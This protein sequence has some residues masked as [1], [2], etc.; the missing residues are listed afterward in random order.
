MRLRVFKADKGDALLLTSKNGKSNMMIDGG[1]GGAYREHCAKTISKL[2]KLDVVY[3]SHIDRD[4]VEGVYQMLDD[5]VAWKV[6]EFLRK[7]GNPNHKPPKN[8]KPPEITKFWQN[9]FH[10]QVGENAGEI[11]DMLASQALTLS[12]HESTAIQEF[13][14]EHQE[15]AQS[16]GDA[17]K[18][19]WR[20]ASDQL[21]IPVNPDFDN[22]LM[23][24]ADPAD[25]FPVGPMRFTLI[26]PYFAELKD[27]KKEWNK[28]LKD[29]KAY[30]ERL[31]KKSTGDFSP[32]VSNSVDSFV[33][34]LSG[35]A[36]DLANSDALI[37]NALSGMA[38]AKT[39][40]SRRKVTTP[41]LA[42]LMFFVSE[43]NRT[44]LLTGDGHCDDVLEGMENANL[45]RSG[46][47]LHVNVLKVPHHGSEHNTSLAFCK[48]ITAD[49]YVFC[50]N[51]AHNN[52]DIDVVKAYIDSRVG[53]TKLR[54]SN[55]E[56]GRKFRLVFNYHP[57]NEAGAR[58]THLKKILKLVKAREK[59]SS[60]LSS[61]FTKGSSASFRV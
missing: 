57:D 29:K 3:I 37:Q 36:E 16:V 56:T 20:L 22:K 21:G 55:P 4:H 46:G 48:A 51:G 10:E 52:P 17:L 30:K 25:V 45:L 50:G 12:G 41:N 18:I 43:G 61:T 13:A 40:G 11:E 39:L 44:L 1:M 42:S 47:T 19:S 32:L 31:K 23:W 6:H 49:K 7:H 35:I 53:P 2:K 8:P 54:S 28:W 5:K 9:N 60:Q 33:A 26:G 14:A 34:P 59:K 15:L 27:L 38:L 24:V 58:K